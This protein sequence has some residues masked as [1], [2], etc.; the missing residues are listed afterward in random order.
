LSRFLPSAITAFCAA[1]IV[2]GIII[3]LG[4]F[5]PPIGR[6]MVDGTLADAMR[7]F[8]SLDAQGWLKLL[9]GAAATSALL[10]AATLV[11]V[12]AFLAMA[13][14]YRWRDARP[15]V[16]TSAFIGPL[17]LAA[18]LLALSSSFSRSFENPVFLAFYLV[19]AVAGALASLIFWLMM[20]PALPWLS[21][22]G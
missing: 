15:I 14:V 17:I 1:N 21:H 2:A 5:S 18:G 22:Q 4:I 19:L 9:Q 3:Y 8:A 10:A 13:W 7:D 12:M 16:L 20:K 6:Q 11:P